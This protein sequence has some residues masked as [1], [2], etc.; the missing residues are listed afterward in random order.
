[1]R[2]GRTGRLI[3][4]CWLLLVT[5]CTAAAPAIAPARGAQAPGAAGVAAPASGPSAAGASPLEALVAAARAEG[6]LTF[7]WGEGTLG[8]SSTIQRLAAGFNKLYGLDVQVQFTPGP[9][10]GVVASK[11][12]QEYQAGQT[13][14][15]DLLIGYPGQIAPV[16][17]ADVLEPVDW[18]S[19]APNV[20]DPALASPDGRAVTFQTAIPGITYN[21]QLVRGAAAPQT[22]QDLLEPQYRGRIAMTTY[23]AY[24]DFLAS[25]DI[26]GSARTLEFSRRFA[27]QVAGLIRCNELERILS[28]EFDLFALTCSQADALAR[29]ASGAPID[30]VIPADAPLAI[31]LYAAVPRNAAHPNAAKLWIN[32]LLSREAQ[33]TIY[34]ADFADSHL[35]PG[36]HTGAA[37][38]RLRSTG[39]PLYFVDLAFYVRQDVP[40]LTAVQDEV[41][42]L[43]LKQ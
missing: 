13:A 41:R 17:Q 16:A 7:L 29:K 6:R 36:S 4:L 35:V 2:R 5:A 40:A 11:V 22:L 43:M 18:T 19:W 38:E 12:L 20:R 34:E 23:A 1:M 27:D 37:I 21:S 15:T 14:S 9:A 24:F 39:V 28:G 30:T 31:Y 10:M 42:R 32:Y 26:W 8:G 25:P 3:A 33:D